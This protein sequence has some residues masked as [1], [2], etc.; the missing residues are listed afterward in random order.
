MKDIVG[1]IIGPPNNMGHDEPEGETKVEW[2]IS[3]AG[4]IS[5][6]HTLC[7]I[8]A[9]DPSIGHFGCLEYKKG[10]K[11]TCSECKSIWEGVKA[12]KIRSTDF[13]K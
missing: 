8:D 12:A 13:E 11:I 3:N 2:H 9:D 7:G 4:G 1:V 6:Y 5:D 10:I